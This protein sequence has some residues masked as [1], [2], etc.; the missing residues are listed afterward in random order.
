MTLSFL[1]PLLGS[2]LLLSFTAYCQEAAEVPLG[3]LPMQY[4]GGFAGEAG[5]PRVNTVAGVEYDRYNGYGLVMYASYDQFIPTIRSGVGVTVGYTGSKE[6]GG[7]LADFISVGKGPYLSLAVAP[8]F[9]I[10]GKVTV[11]PSVN[12]S[13]YWGRNE[14]WNGQADQEYKINTVRSRVGLLFNTEKFYFGYSVHLFDQFKVH[15]NDTTAALPGR[16]F[17][18][19]NSYFQAGYTLGHPTESRFSCTPQLVLRLESPRYVRGGRASFHPVDFNLNFRYKKIIWGLNLT[20]V[21]VGWQTDRLRIVLSDSLDYLERE[22]GYA[23]NIAL[24]YIFKS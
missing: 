16:R 19:F 12:V 5:S 15:Q 9:S 13:L 7:Y 6:A 10:K 20:G 3:A 21:H 14:Y 8:K 4:N 22:P 11:S 23:A 1:T 24:R 17:E 2:L 18:R